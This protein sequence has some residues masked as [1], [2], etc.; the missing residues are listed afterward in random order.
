MGSMTSTSSFPLDEA[1]VSP[2]IG[3]KD[4]PSLDGNGLPEVK[5]TSVQN[6]PEFEPANVPSVTSAEDEV[7]DVLPRST[8]PEDTLLKSTIAVTMTEIPSTE[9][10]FEIN[11]SSFVTADEKIADWSAV[12]DREPATDIIYTDRTTTDD[13]LQGTTYVK[14]EIVEGNEEIEMRAE[15]LKGDEVKQDKIQ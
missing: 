10:T 11:V 5:S 15:D 13:D 12:E 3:Q 9:G 1:G 2:Q 4:R 14:S 8:T 6:T 7:E